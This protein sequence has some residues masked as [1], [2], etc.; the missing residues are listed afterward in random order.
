M[1]L[2]LSAPFCIHTN[3]ELL[4]SV[5]CSLPLNISI[6]KIEA[7]FSLTAIPKP[8][9]GEIYREWGLDTRLVALC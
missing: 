5:F 3:F 4:I 2:F 7:S 9:S 6:D 1:A 8:K